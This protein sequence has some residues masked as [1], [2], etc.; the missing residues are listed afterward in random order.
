[1]PDEWY[2][3]GLQAGL[4]LMHQNQAHTSESGP[5]L[6][7]LVPRSA[8]EPYTISVW[9]HMPESS[10]RALCCPCRDLHARIRAP[11]PHGAS[12]Q[13]HMSGSGS[14]ALCHLFPTPHTEIGAPGLNTTLGHPCAPGLGPTM[15]CA[16][17]V[18]MNNF[19]H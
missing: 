7:L 4:T 18:R 9:L 1:M 13:T 15:P 6:P 19:K 3:A 12:I 11:G 8:P 5:V 10:S 2:R 16:D 14:G 17:N